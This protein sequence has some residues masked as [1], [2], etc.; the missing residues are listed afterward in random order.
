MSR[1]TEKL[2]PLGAL[3]I[4][5]LASSL[6]IA[7]PAYAQVSSTTLRGDVQ[8][9]GA[10]VKVTAHNEET[11]LSRTV[12]TRGD[13]GYVF[14]G[15]PPGTY[16]LSA[17]GPSGV[18]EDV[19]RLQVGQVLNVELVG[20]ATQEIT[21]VG[22]RPRIEVKTSEVGTNVS[23]E[24]IEL[25]PQ[26][27]RNFLNFAQLAP[28][29]RVSR[30]EFR[31]QFSGGASNSVGDS[32]SA[33]QANVF[34]DGV[35][36]KS[37]VNQG[38]I[39]GQDASRGSPFGQSAVAE[40]KVLTQNFK[41][42][43]EQAGSSII[44]AVTKSGTNEFHG[45][46]FGLFSAT[47]FIHRTF[48]EEQNNSPKPTLS[49][50]QFG[51][52]LGGPIIK[53]KLFFYLNYEGRYENRAFD[54]VPLAATA[55]ERAALG[56]DPLASRGAPTSPFREHQG[57]GKLN[58]NISDRQ[59]AEVS[60]NF[61]RNNDIR[62]FG[63][64]TT[65][66]RAN[67]ILDNK[68]YVTF[69]HQFTG[70]NFVNEFLFNYLTGEFVQ[71]PLDQSQP[72]RVY[73]R[74]S[75]PDGAGATTLIT[76]GSATFA[77]RAAERNY[78]FRDNI[79]F[80][81]LQWHGNHVFKTGIRVSRQNYTVSTEPF[82]NPEFVFTSNPAQNLNFSF[83]S[84]A[85]IGLGAPTLD[86]N[87]VQFGVF[88]QDDWDVTNKLQFN[89]GL[90]WDYE[91]NANNN[92]YV[93]PAATAAAL[94][95]F[96]TA[97]DAANAALAA[98]GLP[99]VPGAFNFNAEDYIT[100]GNDRKAFKKAFQPRLGFSYDVFDNSST[101][102]F[103]GWG[104]YYDR[105]LFR[106]A[107]EETVNPLADVRTIRFSLDGLPRNGQPTIQFNPS[108]LTRA[109]LLSLISTGRAPGGEIR[110]LN[111]FQ[112]PPRTDQFSFG[113]R[114]RILGINTSLSW[115]KIIG[116]DDI[117]YVFANRLNY[118]APTPLFVN[119]QQVLNAAGQPVLTTD[120]QPD[121]IPTGSGF[122]S[123]IASTAGQATRYNA[124]YATIDKPYTKAS[125]WGFSAAYTLSFSRQ[126]A[127]TFNFDFA[128]PNTAP[129]VPN[130]A[131]ERHRLVL[132]GIVDL[133]LDFQLSTLTTLASGQPFLVID[134]RTGSGN[135]LRIGDFGRQD[136]IFGFKQ[137]DLTL[138]KNVHVTKKLQVAFTLDVINLLNTTNFNN[139]NGFIG[140]PTVTRNANGTFTT[141][142]G[143][144]GFR[145]PFDL[146]GPPRTLQFGAR[147][148][149]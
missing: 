12:E 97:R 27:T 88:F 112:P 103:G 51:A 91:T 147:I 105:T 134:T 131:D 52:D 119:G 128:N 148:A 115:S 29:V 84:Q 79:T 33:G 85:Q 22:G 143:F 47:P 92:K 110:V 70:D 106:N 133:P 72:G 124:L 56:F 90:R 62:D 59:T 142:T 48:F 139:R 35:S 26:N 11:G 42:E 49:R 100:N 64:T 10:G 31:Q 101:V 13:G 7:A 78:T 76:L 61:T 87:N 135:L 2:T 4:A 114:Q 28:G 68:T 20:A 58:W 3:K 118:D 96:Q 99:L 5:L 14:I 136:P 121:A 95:A 24:Q 138:R 89:I 104:R 40:F 149:F 80:S 141:T 32:L 30:D 77:Q 67:D 53:D 15:L 37:N 113:V 145:T 1:I 146:A 86:A 21:V 38:G 9:V 140:T 111:D 46:A 75:G 71:Q 50:D 36:L 41:A 132:T 39:I 23:R 73:Q 82:N 34:I 83:P 94:R 102:V 122:G 130:G 117:A 66:G 144:E 107:A 57:F 93:T 69:K 8:G 63:G 60:V 19:V 54:I 123:V 126:R 137:I 74:S 81:D 116:V 43:Y 120:G 18:A 55:A 44:T 6:L 98:Q 17:E 125:H 129:F 16:R 45:G 65:F 108:F 25:L 127:S 109:G